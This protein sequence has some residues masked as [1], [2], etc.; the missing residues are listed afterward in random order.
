MTELQDKS[1]QELAEYIEQLES[2]LAKLQSQPSPKNIESPRIFSKHGNPTWSKHET[3]R[4]LIA[5]DDQ[6]IRILIAK[7]LGYEFYDLAEAVSGEDAIS[8]IK[9]MAG[10]LDVVLLDIDM[11][12]VDGFKVLEAI[13]SNPDSE[14]IKVIMLTATTDMA[15]KI[16]AFKNGAADY[17]PKP[18]SKEE[19]RARVG[20]QLEIKRKEEDLRKSEQSYR[21]LS[22]LL[23]QT[24]FEIDLKGNFLFL[25]RHGL[26]LTGYTQADMESGKTKIWDIFVAE[27]HERISRNI[28]MKLLGEMEESNGDSEYTMLAKDGRAFPVG[29]YSSAIIRDDQMIGLR[30]TILDLTEHQH[31]KNERREKEEEYRIIFDSVPVSLVVI[32]P[33]GK[34]VDINSTHISQI[35]G[36]KVTKEDYLGQNLLNHPS[37]VQAGLTDLYRKAIEGESFSKDNVYFPSVTRGTN[38]RFNVK[39]V[40]IARDGKPTG[41]ILFHEDITERQQIAEQLRQKEAEYHSILTNMTDTLMKIDREGTIFFVNRFHAGYQEDGVIGK[42]IFDFM[43]ED[44]KADAASWLGQVFEYGKTV[45]YEIDGIGSIESSL[46]YQLRISPAWE[47]GEI[48]SAIYIISDITERKQ[49]ENALKQSEEKFRSLYN[50]MIEGVCLY[51]IIY[52]EANK[53]IDYLITDINHAYESI[54]GLNREQVVGKKA[55]E[56]CQIGE[57]PYLDIYA[58]VTATGEPCN[59]EAYFPPLDKHFAISVFRPENGKFAT[60]FSDMT[61]RKQAV[62][63]LTKKINELERYKNVTVDRE[64]MMVELKEKI[65]A[66]EDD[67]GR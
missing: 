60:I 37:I 25:N 33:D 31:A 64:L 65:R 40:P 56:L 57:P 39:G 49:I 34:I 7:T 53:A 8:L 1:K 38:G 23:P 61:E 22:E 67:L 9:E 2:E 44:R 63:E 17:L 15:N 58:R 35:A 30:G 6:S 10:F 12:E 48:V 26:K 27:D 16:R 13:K 24:I 11:G 47:D 32:D 46:A 3:G 52:D 55:S 50:T 29:V 45:S 41:A 20:V 21:E 54:I 4:I 62:N 18:F 43:S 14:G 42:T 59:F 51:E 36:N 19:L 5:D 66:L 28:A